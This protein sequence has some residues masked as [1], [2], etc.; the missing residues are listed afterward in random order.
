MVT[1]YFLASAASRG[2]SL[3]WSITASSG[4][5]MIIDCQAISPRSQSGGRCTVKCLSNQLR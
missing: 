1:P 5:E 4:L 2:K 3:K